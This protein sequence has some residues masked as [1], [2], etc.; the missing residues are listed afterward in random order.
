M[1][2]GLAAC[3]MHDAAFD[4][5][6][7]AVENSYSILRAEILQKSVEQ[8]QG[9]SPYFDDLLSSALVLPATAKRPA[10]SYLEYHRRFIFRDG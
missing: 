8:D 2:N 5:G 4:R 9:V 10:I 1:R 3:P 6:Y 7:L